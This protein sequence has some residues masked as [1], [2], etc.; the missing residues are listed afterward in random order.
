MH[1]L[2]LNLLLCIAV[3]MKALFQSVMRSCHRPE[4]WWPGPVGRRAQGQHT[5]LKAYGKSS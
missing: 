1:G 5:S 3:N 4:S 2:I